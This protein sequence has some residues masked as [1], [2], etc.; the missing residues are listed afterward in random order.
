MPELSDTVAIK[1]KPSMT[2]DNVA[3]LYEELKTSLEETPKKVIFE[4][5]VNEEIDFMTLQTLAAYYEHRKAEGV[6][7][8]WDNPSIAIFLRAVELGIGDALG[9]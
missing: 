4:C 7:I 9:L 8:V 6:K 3:E 1:F 2:M 5:A